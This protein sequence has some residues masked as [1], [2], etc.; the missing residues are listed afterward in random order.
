MFPR[1][2]P[3]LEPGQSLSPPAPQKLFCYVD[4]SGQDTVGSFFI[5]SVVAIRGARGSLTSDLEAIELATGKKR[6]KWTHT[7]AAVRAS[8]I[9]SVF[10]KPAF[11][12]SL[13][14]A[15]YRNT[16]DYLGCTIST[17]A[18]AIHLCATMPKYD[19]TVFVDGLPR[20]RTRRFG[21]ELRRLGIR[22]KKVRGVRKEESDALMRLADGLCGF[23]RAGLY[24]SGYSP[25]PALLSQARFNGVLREV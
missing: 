24:G 10:G 1:L 11:Q 8:Y 9:Q 19:V 7:K 6:S 3:R 5:V 4:E 20:S 23:V 13:M 16:T 18:R 17:V 12:G 15:I 2:S 25:F 21:V 14:Y 22:T